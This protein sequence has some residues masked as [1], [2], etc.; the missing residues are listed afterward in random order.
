MKLLD[1]CLKLVFPILIILAH[2]GYN[3]HAK[4]LEKDWRMLFNG[5]DLEGWEF[6]G[7]AGESAPRFTVEEGAIVGRTVIPYNPTAFMA[8]TESFKDFELI[9]EVKVDKE[10]NSG[11]Q[12]R[13]TAAGAVKGPQVEIENDS[14]KTGY[15]FGQGMGMW[16]SDDISPANKAF[17]S[18]DWN[19]FR[20]LV[21]GQNIRTWINDVPVADTTHERIDSEGVIA[22]Q[23]HGYPRGKYREAGAREILS[24]SW[25]NIKVRVFE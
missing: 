6:R 9:F 22:L 19:Q 17:K 20:V 21:K 13:S 24:A 14:P 8:T 5:K 2:I 11:V 23:I 25:R 3:I 4:E 10:L 7:K 15:I 12:V 16:L 1:S 18:N